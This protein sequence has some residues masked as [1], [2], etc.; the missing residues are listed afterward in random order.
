MKCGNDDNSDVN[1][2]EVFQLLKNLKNITRRQQYSISDIQ[3]GELSVI[4]T[5]LFDV[6]LSTGKMPSRWKQAIVTPVPKV[7]QKSEFTGLSD[8]RPISVT[9]ILS[10]ESQLEFV[11]N[12]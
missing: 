5:H 1:E 7:K 3:A 11:K 2:Y 10:R 6:S 9:P 8:L 4:V 12:Y